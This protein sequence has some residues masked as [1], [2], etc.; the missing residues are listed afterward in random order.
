MQRM[1]P[2]RDSSM[3]A[4]RRESSGLRTRAVPLEAFKGQEGRPQARTSDPSVNQT[5]RILVEVAEAPAAS[6]SGASYKSS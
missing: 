4:H 1:T 5:T 2:A 3:I 6:S